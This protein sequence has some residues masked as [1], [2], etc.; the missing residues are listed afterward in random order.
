MI[1]PNVQNLDW[2][3]GQGKVRVEQLGGG[4]HTLNFAVQNGR[5]FF[6]WQ[7]FTGRIKTERL[8]LWEQWA[9]YLSDCGIT[10]RRLIACHSFGPEPSRF[11]GSLIY[12]G[13]RGQ[14]IPWSDYTLGRICRATCYL[15]KIH[16]AG[17]NF[18][19]KSR[20]ARIALPSEVQISSSG[21]E[22][23]SGYRINYKALLQIWRRLSRACLNG[24]E[25]V[26][27]GDFGRGNIIFDD[28]K[29]AGVIDWESMAWG[30]PLFDLGRF[31][32][33]LLLDTALPA[34]VVWATLV[35]NY[36]LNILST[37]DL[38][39]ATA[40]CWWQDWLAWRRT[41][42]P[43]AEKIRNRLREHNLIEKL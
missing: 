9:R 5:D 10:T 29:I 12:R 31:G 30:N 17:Q 39:A 22:T 8:Q 26:L 2:L 40:W 18:P 33:Y 4:L 28:D 35:E 42:S 1:K 43:L 25:T 3:L 32:G 11:S 21:D 14:S 6:I 20:L 7:L 37:A 16:R 41:S 19:G 34:S 23:L 36:R 24:P 15:E 38:E 27:H 13:V